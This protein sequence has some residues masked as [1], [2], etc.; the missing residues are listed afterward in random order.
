MLTGLLLALTVPATAGSH[1]GMASSVGKRASAL[2]EAVK[3]RQPT[4]DSIEN[5][6]ACAADP[7]SVPLIDLALPFHIEPLGHLAPP[8]HTFPT[9]HTYFQMNKSTDDTSSFNIYAPGQIKVTTVVQTTLLNATPPS[10][11]YGIDFVPCSGILGRLGHV[12]NLGTD[13]AA[14]LGPFTDCSTANGIQTCTKVVS[15]SQEAGQ[16]IGI[17]TG[18]TGSSLVGMD[19]GLFD[20]NKPAQS[21]ISPERRSDYQNHIVC[22]YDYFAEPIRSNLE[23]RF[24]RYDGLPRTVVPLC[25]EANQDLPGTAQ[26]NWYPKGTP[27]TLGRWE[28]NSLA[29][30][31]DNVIPSTGIFSV[32]L[33]VSASSLPANLYAFSPQPSGLVN[34][35][36]KDVTSDNNVYCY[37][38]FTNFVPSNVILIKMPTSS[39]LLI[40]RQNIADCS[41][42]GWALTSSATEFER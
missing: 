22:P 15:I 16:V 17:Q 6:S 9:D 21:F 13:L 7:L 33:G 36:F 28:D 40:E 35:D 10:T 34:R 2:N 4:P 11:D 38:S 20:F 8:P 29:L 14:A 1:I 24:S 19:F 31:H 32:G 18:T 42:G 25:G 3:T 37:D 27:H 12:R 5:P 39:T 30:V 41:G 23:A 26:G